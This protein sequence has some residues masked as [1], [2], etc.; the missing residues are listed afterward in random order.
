MRKRC[1]SWVVRVFEVVRLSAVEKAT[2]M[3]EPQ[4][5]FAASAMEIFVNK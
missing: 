5:L 2:R 3:L 1:H 4:L